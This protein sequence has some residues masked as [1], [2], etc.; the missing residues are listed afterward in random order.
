MSSSLQENSVSRPFEIVTVASP[1]RCI[2]QRRV[3]SGA[4][5]CGRAEFDILMVYERDVLTIKNY[6]DNISPEWEELSRRTE[7]KEE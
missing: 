6:L 5:D 3:C 1:W 4:Y 2:G 7:R